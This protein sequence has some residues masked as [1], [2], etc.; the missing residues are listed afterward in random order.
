MKSLSVNC[1]PFLKVKFLTLITCCAFLFLN[2]SCRVEV[3]SG[4][5]FANKFVAPDFRA[6]DI[7]DWQTFRQLSDYQ[8]SHVVLL[9]LNDKWLSQNQDAMA[10]TI[11]IVQ[12]AA[13]NQKVIFLLFAPLLRTQIH[14]YEGGP[15]HPSYSY[16]GR[17]FLVE[18]NFTDAY[19]LG[20][21][22]LKVATLYGV[23][24]SPHVILIDPNG[25]IKYQGATSG[26]PGAISDALDGQ[27]LVPQF[28]DAEIP[29]DS[30]KTASKLQVT[31]LNLKG[32]ADAPTEPLSLW[33]RQPA[34]DWETEAL[35]LGNGS[36]GAMVFGGITNERI[37][38]TEET[39]WE[40]GPDENGW[41][42]PDPLGT[43]DPNRWKREKKIWA[44][45]D[46]VNVHSKLLGFH[47]NGMSFYYGDM[48]H[49]QPMGW[50]NMTF[51]SSGDIRNYKRQ[52][53]IRR[54]V[55]TITYEQGN[56]QLTREYFCSNVD[57]VMVMRLGS[58]KP[59]NMT[60]DLAF[61]FNAVKSVEGNTLVG[62]GAHPSNDLKYTVRMA[63]DSKDGKIVAT[64]DGISVITGSEVTV[65]MA[66]ATDY[67][68]VWP[69]YRGRDPEALTKQRIANAKSKPYNKLLADHASEHRELMDRMDLDF[70]GAEMK[71]LPTDERLRLYKAEGS[72]DR[73]LETLL[74]QF[75]R[76]ILVSSSRKNSQLPANLQ[77]VWNLEKVPFAWSCFFLDIDQEMNYWAAET[78]N[79][80]DLSAPHIR[81]INSLRPAGRV[82]AETFYGSRGWT[83]GY[84]GGPFG[85]AGLSLIGGYNQYGLWR[86]SAAWLCQNVWDHY[87]FSGEIEFLK[88]IGYPI[89]KE[90]AE[91]FLDDLVEMKDGTLLLCPSSSPENLE[92]GP[93][94]TRGTGFGQQ[95]AWDIL[96]NTIEASEILDLDP[97]FR[98]ECENAFNRLS[99]NKI[100]RRGQ[101]QEW[102]DDRGVVDTRHRHI[103]HLAGLY[104]GREISVEK[105]PELAKAARVTMQGRETGDM[106]D[107]VAGHKMCLY[108]RLYEP[109]KA[110]TYARRIL[111]GEG[112]RLFDNMFTSTLDI[113][114]IDG[115]C[116]YVAGVAEML[117][118]SHLGEIHLLP[119]LPKAWGT[120][121]AKG[122][123]ARTG[124]EVD[125]KW[126]NMKAISAEVRPK[127]DNTRKIRAPKG[128]TITAIKSAGNEVEFDLDDTGA[129]L[130][131]M[132]A[133]KTYQ[134]QF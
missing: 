105:T 90:C 28:I 100:G 110:Y 73:H 1:R 18:E 128:Q 98:N 77:G 33:Y 60:V 122:L 115:N 116:G 104:P 131:E 114:Q 30:V 75:G 26:F 4:H 13:G 62:R 107:W 99:P 69:T 72:P 2:A 59:I 58:S 85:I 125:L 57:Q 15:D 27:I 40:G 108:S 132:K 82:I 95:M 61:D 7:A 5:G 10:E 53:D 80:G 126:E 25:I 55:H 129:A 124:I 113:L 24:V 97:E 71:E 117:I 20:D 91:F 23:T 81:F 45:T 63:V 93:L 89:M 52:L 87:A 32:K 16:L 6:R 64:K 101:L 109:E 50:V 12:S 70:G 36:I 96:N 46:D 47:D 14:Q 31:A 121:S 134:L 48:S 11:R 119:A 35:P 76:Y 3:N 92:H 103:S 127:I 56:V 118:Q 49:Y 74:F 120:G 54:G 39:F 37:Q 65:V 123:C 29:L 86:E 111:S 44:G 67:E 21:P 102:Y 8:D 34:F 133:G 88:E 112:D 106:L 79:L 9:W 83:C 68:Q 22:G 43:A 94:V 84:F 130:V 17:N 42:D 78:G 51:D 41:K 66:V 38:F 19:A